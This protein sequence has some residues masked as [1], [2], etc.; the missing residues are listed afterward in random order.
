MYLIHYYY[1]PPK[2]Q[3]RAQRSDMQK[4]ENKNILSSRNYLEKQ[5]DSAHPTMESALI[6]QHIYLSQ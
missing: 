6:A 3:G 5:S 4:S 1:C 2:H